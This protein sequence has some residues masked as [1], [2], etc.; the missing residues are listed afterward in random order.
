VEVSLAV[1]T[2]SLSH[3]FTF[4][5]QNTWSESTGR[6]LQPSD[7]P[8]VSSSKPLKRFLWNFVPSIYPKI[9]HMNLILVCINP[10]QPLLYV[11]LKSNITD[12]L[13]HSLLCRKLIH[14]MKYKL[15]QDLQFILI[16]VTSCNF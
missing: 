9:C 2:D 1:I 14:K 4:H 16:T 6:R 13:K 5:K 11:K 7:C 3:Q 10:I 8:H 12:F 15:Q